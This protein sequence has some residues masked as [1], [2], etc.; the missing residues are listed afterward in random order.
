M[1]MKLTRKKK[2]LL[3][4]VIVI[5]VGFTIRFSYVINR[6]FP[7]NDGGF[8]YSMIR[9]L[10]ANDWRLP[11]FSTYNHSLIP[12]MYPP[13]GFY[14]ALFLT[15]CLSINLLD[16][17]IYLPVIFSCLTLIAFLPLARG[18]LSNDREY[19]LAILMFAM[20]DPGY[21]WII[22]GGGITRGLGFVFA[23]LALAYGWR[24][25]LTG[26][27]RDA[28]L[29]ALFC[30]LALLSH[31]NKTWFA[32]ISIGCFFFIAGRNRKGVLHS[33]FIILLVILFSTPWWVT[34]VRQHGI[35][36]IIAAFS[37][38]S[39]GWEMWR[40]FF[41]Y[42]LYGFLGIIV[43][44]LRKEFVLPTWFLLLNI[45]DPRN[46]YTVAIVPLAMLMSRGYWQIVYPTW[47]RIRGGD[48]HV[49]P[50]IAQSIKKIKRKVF[51]EMEFPLLDRT[52]MCVV[53][54]LSCG[55]ILHIGVEHLR[56]LFPF[57]PVQSL[58]GRELVMMEWIKTEIPEDQDFLILSADIWW[59]DKIA[60]WFP[61]LT[62]H[63][64][65]LTAQGHEWVSSSFFTYLCETHTEVQN[66][67]RDGDL[68]SILNWQSSNGEK[69]DYLYYS[70]ARMNWLMEYHCCEQLEEQLM[71]SPALKLVHR[72]GETMIFEIVVDG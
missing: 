63:R 44:L 22:M 4:T 46:S 16:L 8:F 21:I 14:I 33:I 25:Y 32:L 28:V 27:T 61:A 67:V 3:L 17:F 20:L 68:A 35:S 52:M 18:F 6:Q 56:L 50:A 43:C 69:P 54:M 66:W 10:Q 41:V 38:E 12:F 36:P 24:M 34:I 48:I 60:E 5:L 72:E 7:L 64:S 71:E 55:I 53:I 9:D 42:T 58:E 40:T 51:G 65:I 29:C 13:L 62:G 49:D 70:T 30:S 39:S 23:F 31:P 1:N 2:Q 11:A 26:R 59:N 37:T 47:R 57:S 19:Y 45:L 15:D